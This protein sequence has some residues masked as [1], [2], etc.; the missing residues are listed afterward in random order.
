MSTQFDFVS[1]VKKPNI[2]F[3]GLSIS[4]TI[5]FKNG[6]KK[7]IGVILPTERP[8]T[9]ETHVPERIEIISGKCHVQITNDLESQ[10]YYAGQSFYVPRKS[11]FSIM[12]DD[13]LDYICHLEG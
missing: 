12:T 10:V 3:D 2:C 11:R 4:R 1:V 6:I 5:Q 7:T 13:V 9:F 8:L